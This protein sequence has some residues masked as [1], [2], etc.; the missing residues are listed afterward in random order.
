MRNPFRAPGG[1]P[2][3]KPAII[4]RLSDWKPPSTLY[5]LAGSDLVAYLAL[6]PPAIRERVVRLDSAD[7][8][9]VALLAQLDPSTR[10]LVAEL[11][12][13]Y[14]AARRR[15]MEQFAQLDPDHRQQLEILLLFQ[16]DAPLSPLMH[17][18]QL[19][20]VDRH[21]LTEEFAQLDPVDWKRFLTLP[22]RLHD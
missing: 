2:Q 7:W 8:P 12:R 21:L 19:D 13:L 6:L 18:A 14:P 9:L 17:F 11:A 5:T 1:L 20:P 15:H 16:T 4:K 3:L 22:D 10:Q